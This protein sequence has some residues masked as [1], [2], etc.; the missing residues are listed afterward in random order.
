ML[1]AW[2]KWN[3]LV[4][5][6]NLDAFALGAARTW[7]VGVF[8]HLNLFGISCLYYSC[9]RNRHCRWFAISVHVISFYSST[10]HPPNPRSK[11]MTSDF[12]TSQ[13]LQFS[14]ICNLIEICEVLEDRP[15]VCVGGTKVLG[16]VPTL[17]R[18]NGWKTARLLEHSKVD[19]FRCQMSMLRVRCD[20]PR[21]DKPVKSCLILFLWILCNFVVI[22]LAG[23]IKKF[24]ACHN[25]VN[26]LKDGW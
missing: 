8:L 9:H 25:K 16:D 3:Q 21:N 22:V 14:V 19:W 2:S 5:V 26:W 1:I 24:N 10:N 23:F 12:F 18:A 20:K 15:C 11:R 4:W 17:Y 13:F 7:D 6:S